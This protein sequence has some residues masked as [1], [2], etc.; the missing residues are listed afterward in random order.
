[1]RRK[2]A[3]LSLVLIGVFMAGLL[4]LCSKSKS[5]YETATTVSPNYPQSTE[6]KNT[7]PNF[8]EIEQNVPQTSTTPSAKQN[9]KKE[10]KKA[11]EISENANLRKTSNSAGEVIDIIP[12]ETEIEIVKQKGAWFYVKAGGKSGWMHGNT[13]RFSEPQIA[14]STLTAETST[15][16]ATDYSYPPSYSSGYSGSGYSSRSS[17]SSSYDY[18]PKTVRVR[19]YYRKD[20][21]FVRSHTRR[22]PSRRR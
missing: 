7:I 18:R 8:N 19:S 22:S 1:M 21:T 10:S 4:G 3:N 2:K 20:G 6:I 13:I 14:D 5:T 15:P 12:Q 9:N 16:P 11:V 17:S